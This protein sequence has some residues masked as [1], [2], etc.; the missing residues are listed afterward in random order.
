MPKYNP[1]DP[2]L[3]THQKPKQAGIGD[4]LAAPVGFERKVS[5]EKQTPFL[6]VRFTVLKDYEGTGDERAEVW[7]NF[8]L[9][10]NAMR[11]FNEFVVAMGHRDPY[12]PDDDDDIAKI[13]AKGYVDLEVAPQ[14]WKGARS[15]TPKVEARSFRKPRSF[16]AKD[17]WKEWISTA[18]KN[19]A[20]YL[21]WRAEH[22]Y[23]SGGGRGGDGGGE[24]GGGGDHD[25]GYSSEGG[26]D[27]SQPGG[28]DPLPFNLPVA[29]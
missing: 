1:N 11:F 17:E 6:C 24:Y 4:K 5:G 3:K 19:H 23:G 21:A 25:G 22:P 13:L 7:R 2:E 20:S 28:D 12:D 18:E 8:A 26:Y 10:Q 27:E 14:Q 9:T 16:V 29:A 15:R